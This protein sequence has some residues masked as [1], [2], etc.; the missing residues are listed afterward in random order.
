MLRYARRLIC[1]AKSTTWIPQWHFF[2]SEKTLE[3]EKKKGKK[4]S[5]NLVLCFTI[6]AP[7]LTMQPK[8]IVRWKDSSN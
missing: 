1:R 4:K 7:K 5:K 2:L 6:A 8:P 3:K